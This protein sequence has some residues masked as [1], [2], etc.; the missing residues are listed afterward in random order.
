M[1]NGRRTPGVSRAARLEVPCDV[2]DEYTLTAVVEC[3]VTH[4]LFLM[5]LIV[6]GVQTTVIIDGWSMTT[7]GIDL[8]DGKTFEFNETT[9]RGH[10]LLGD[11][12]NMIVC[13]VRKG[14]LQVSCNGSPLID[15]SGDRRRLSVGSSWKVPHNRR[16]FIGSFETPFQVVKLE[17]APDSQRGEPSEG[18]RP[19]EKPGPAVSDNDWTDLFDGNS[20][21]GWT[22]D[23][24]AMRVQNGMLVN[25][26]KRAIVMA[27]G[28]HEDFEIELEFR[29]AKGGNSGLG[30]CYS[31]SGDPSQNGLEVQ[32]L[33]DAANRRLQDI[34][35]C[36]AVYGVAAAKAGHFKRWPEWNRLRVTSQT[37]KLRPSR[38]S[39]NRTEWCGVLSKLRI[40]NNLACDTS[41]PSTANSRSLAR[42]PARAAGL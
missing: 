39:C 15:W 19:V 40:G 11:V 16:L 14:A 37:S 7:S 36:G 42:T 35:R 4:D 33:E 2:P 41:A 22:G 25:N 29:L 20:L 31:G 17:L 6:G 1:A 26:G 12:P 24:G 23:V 13:I 18:A 34:Q 5:G 8:L 32:M 10:F 21:A 28:D 30:I 27:P 38:G 9:K 3:P